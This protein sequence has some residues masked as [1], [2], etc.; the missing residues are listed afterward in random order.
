MNFSA[1]YKPEL[2]K[3]EQGQSMIR[4][5]LQDEVEFV[6][7]DF[8]T[9]KRSMT[10]PE[11]TLRNRM[12]D[13]VERLFPKDFVIETSDMM[14]KGSAKDSASEKVGRMVPVAVD[15]RDGWLQIGWKT[16]D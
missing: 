14:V 2:A 8:E 4:F 16:I 5:T 1:C 6:P 13:A 15:A 10:K 12:G 11:T 9:Q 7:R 3:D